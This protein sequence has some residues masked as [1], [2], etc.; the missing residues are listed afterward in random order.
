MSELIKAIPSWVIEEIG[1]FL[2]TCFRLFFYAIILGSAISAVAQ[3]LLENIAPVCKA[4][5]LH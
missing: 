1:E 4:F 5:G 2:W 3:G